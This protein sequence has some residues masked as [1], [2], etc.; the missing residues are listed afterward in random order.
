MR[1]VPAS[2]GEAGLGRWAACAGKGTQEGEWGTRWGGEGQSLPGESL[3]GD[4]PKGQGLGQPPGPQR[5]TGSPKA[6][7]T[8]KPQNSHE[9][10][11]LS[12]EAALTDAGT[13]DLSAWG[14][15]CCAYTTF[16]S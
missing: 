3:P 4:D 9:C 12:A 8:R 10:S 11:D 6:L 15:P 2:R 7:R 13:V 16:S 14:D 1:S 5:G